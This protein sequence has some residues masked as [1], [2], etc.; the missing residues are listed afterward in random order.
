MPQGSRLQI[1][2][3]KEVDEFDV[4]LDEEIEGVMWEIF[5]DQNPIPWICNT[6]GQAY[7]IALGCQWGAMRQNDKM[8]NRI[9]DRES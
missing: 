2:S 4:G 9:M 1:K 5:W 3:N 8:I 6:R 7:A